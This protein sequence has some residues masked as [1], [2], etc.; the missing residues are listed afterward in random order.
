[1]TRGYGERMD[2]H[3]CAPARERAAY[4][5]LVALLATLL[6][7]TALLLGAP[8]AAA[9]DTLVGSSPAADE[10]VEPPA[11]LVLSFSA[12]ISPVGAAAEVTGP[13]GVV[14]EG[15]PVVEGRE[16][17]VALAP[18]LPSG[19]YD[20]AWRVTSSDGHPISGEFGF[21]VEAEQETATPEPTTEEP[22]PTTEPTETE[23]PSPTTET[24]TVTEP[25]P[26]T[27][28]GTS[29]DE[30]TSTAPEDS[31]GGDDS[32]SPWVWLLAGAVVLVLAGLAVA[33]SRRGS[34]GPEETT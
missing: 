16:L 7:A 26:T 14:S 8:G 23:Q 9:H 25:A 31:A 17:T 21:Q 10:V 3:G 19:S 12:E 1:M 20:V 13:P 30:P 2:T 32:V 24:E 4:P 5:V 15:T 27:T 29:E 28:P 6:G 18:D 34:A 33:V 11:E 22:A